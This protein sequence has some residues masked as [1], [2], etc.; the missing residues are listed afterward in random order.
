M[1]RKKTQNKPIMD[2]ELVEQQIPILWRDNET[3]DTVYANN[4]LITNTDK[5]FY[6]IFGE[7]V[8]PF[9]Y[10]QPKPEYGEVKPLVRIAVTPETM[11]SIS[12]AIQRTVKRYLEKLEK[13]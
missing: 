5:E 10:D 4:L 6:L 7:F 2:N 9:R 1:P 12:E 11:L 8:P 13:S 3:L